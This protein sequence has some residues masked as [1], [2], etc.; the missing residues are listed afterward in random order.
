MDP[1]ELVLLDDILDMD[2][3]ECGLFTLLQR[4][5]IGP[6]IELRKRGAAKRW[7]LLI[8]RLFKQ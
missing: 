8:C 3:I 7:Q 1:P 5:A 4:S 6:A 2:I